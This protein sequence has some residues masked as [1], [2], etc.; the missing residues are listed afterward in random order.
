MAR[1]IGVSLPRTS[2]SNSRCHISHVCGIARSLARGI[3]R[4]PKISPPSSGPNAL[5]NSHSAATQS[6]ATTKSAALR[7]PRLITR[8]R[9][10]AGEGLFSKGRDHV[11]AVLGERV[12]LAVVLE[13]DRE[14]VDAQG[15]QRM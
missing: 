7:R 12:V 11:L 2:G 8:R 1:Q 13:I 6:R 4:H 9:S 10:R 3:R 5:Y 14:L 15:R